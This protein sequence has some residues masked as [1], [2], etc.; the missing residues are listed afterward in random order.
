LVRALTRR[1]AG[2]GEED[3]QVAGVDPDYV[4]GEAIDLVGG[5]E[6]HEGRNDTRGDDDLWARSV[7][8]A[9]GA[10]DVQQC[11]EEVRRG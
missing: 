6:K 10:V 9:V 4:V 3:A 5:E 2:A 8:R 11:R 7:R 1:A